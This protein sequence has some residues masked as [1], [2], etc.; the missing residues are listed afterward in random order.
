MGKLI[1]L[2]GFLFA[3]VAA[4][5]PIARLLNSDTR[6]NE[7]GTKFDQGDKTPHVEV[8]NPVRKTLKRTLKTP[9]D[10]VPNQEI[11]IYARISGYSSEL[12]VDRGS[13]VKKNDVLAV[14]SVPELEKQKEREEAELALCD[15][16]EKRDEAQVEWKKSQ[17]E[18][19]KALLKKSPNLITEDMVEELEGKFKTAKEELEITRKRKAILK[20]S[21]QKTEE[22]LKFAK[23]TAPFTG[24]ITERWIDK[25]D[26]IQPGA[27][28]LVHLMD[29]D[30]L[31]V[32]IHVPE[33]DVPFIRLEDKEN[34]EKTKITLTIDEIKTRKFEN[35]PISRSAWALN[36]NTKTMMIEV[37]LKN[38][39]HEVRPGMFAYITLDL[40]SYNN[41]LVVPASALVVEKKKAFL[42]VVRDGIA[43]KIPVTIGLDT[44]IDV[45][46]IEEKDGLKDNDQVVLTGKN[47]ISDGERVRA[48]MRGK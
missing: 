43:K 2:A 46:I 11:T 38:E 28:K 45:E 16:T 32:R 33:P 20:A 25:G 35:I 21:L 14:I 31:R 3:A 22:M 36:R 39:S 4:S 47:I 17:Y 19:G 10:I 6:K 34:S 18:R 44:G 15:P 7:I 1:I 8:I 29:V 26:L 23:I 42:F 24:V 5:V 12:K 27:T 48:T 30:T 40:K 37:D 41:A 9:A 13:W